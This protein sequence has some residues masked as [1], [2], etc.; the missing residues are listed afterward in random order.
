MVACI[1][2]KIPKF[3]CS[4]AVAGRLAEAPVWG[5]AERD[6]EKIH[7]KRLSALILDCWKFSQN[8]ILYQG[9][10]NGRCPWICD[11][12][13]FGTIFREKYLRRH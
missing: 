7:R 10:S 13:A 5:K 2:I 9:L 11:Y 1:F 4:F 8:F 3:I 6:V 12:L